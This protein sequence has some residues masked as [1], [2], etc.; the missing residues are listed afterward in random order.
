MRQLPRLSPLPL[1][2]IALLGWGVIAQAPPTQGTKRVNE[3]T[4]AGLRPGKDTLVEASRIFK[5]EHAARDSRPESPEW[6]DGCTGRF[7]RLEIGRANLIEGVTVSSLGSS[8][9]EC[10][11]IPPAW[12]QAK[13]LRTGR[14]VGLGSS[15]SNVTSTYGPPQS[16]GPSTLNGRQLELLYYAFDWAGTDVPQVMEVTIEKG[17]V[18]QITLAYPSL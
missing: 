15:K 5:P 18:V 4:L 11:A 10:R 1:A 3:L 14:G 17:R 12:L 6:A 7:V 2:A 16:S 9:A 13:L 8:N